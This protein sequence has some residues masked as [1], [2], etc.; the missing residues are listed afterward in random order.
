MNF[1]YINKDNIY[2]SIFDVVYETKISCWYKLK[3]LLNIWLTAWMPPLWLDMES[4][5]MLMV[6]ISYEGLDLGQH[7]LR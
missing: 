3:Q 2:L 7:W 5:K 4:G 1:T 6:I